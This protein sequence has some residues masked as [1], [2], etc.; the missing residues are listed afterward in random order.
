LQAV[1]GL[2]PAALGAVAEVVLP[3]ELGSTGRATAVDGFL[4]WLRGYRPG[5]ELLHPYGSGDL[6]LTGPSPAPR[7]AGQLS[8]LDREAAGRGA[9]TFAALSQAVRAELIEAALTQHKLDRVPPPAEANHV[10]VGLLAYFLATP[11]AVDLCYRMRIGK[12]TCRPL[13]ANPSRP[14]PTKP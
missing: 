14:E 13:S 9:A 12:L 10:A 6:G 7:W 2:D 11:A 5:A 1:A 3:T 4:R 8:S